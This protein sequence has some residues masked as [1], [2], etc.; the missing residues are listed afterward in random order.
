MNFERLACMRIPC[1]GGFCEEPRGSY[2]LEGVKRGLFWGPH[3][4]RDEQSYVAL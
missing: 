4:E 2:D 1:T 3:R